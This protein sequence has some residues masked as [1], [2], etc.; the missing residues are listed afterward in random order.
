MEGRDVQ[1]N[2]AKGRGSQY[3]FPTPLTGEA[4]MLTFELVSGLASYLCI[5]RIFF[6]PFAAFASCTVAD[7]DGR[8]YVVAY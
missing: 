1:R 6:Q 5:Y 2:N 3:Y 7:E 4:R 8:L